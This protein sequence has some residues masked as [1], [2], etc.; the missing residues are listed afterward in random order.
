[1]IPC[2]DDSAAIYVG[3]TMTVHN[4]KCFN[5][6]LQLNIL[7]GTFLLVSCSS[8]CTV[9]AKNVNKNGI[10]ERSLSGFIHNH[11][12]LTKLI[13]NNYPAYQAIF[14]KIEQDNCF[15]IQHTDNKAHVYSRKAGGDIYLSKK[16]LV[17]FD[18]A[19]TCMN[20]SGSFVQI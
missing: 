17:T 4:P 8:L 19:R 10:Q 1:M 14:C 2:H 6:T 16:K 9:K 11:C 20:E 13:F 7:A 15:I 12:L 5:F 18:R 3:R